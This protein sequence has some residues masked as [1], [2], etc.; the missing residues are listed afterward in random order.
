MAKS[1]E[2]IALH[3]RAYK[4][5][6]KKKEL[7]IKNNFPEPNWW[8]NYRNLLDQVGGLQTSTKLSQTQPGR[9]QLGWKWQNF[10]QVKVVNT[11]I[12]IDQMHEL[13]GSK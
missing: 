13:D 2:N 11:N 9:G 6:K 8:L 1:L 5:L 12:Y 10:L 4:L 3:G 7:R